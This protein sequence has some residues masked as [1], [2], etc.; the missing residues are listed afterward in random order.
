MHQN[1]HSDDQQ[2]IVRLREG[3]IKTLAELHTRY[4]KTLLFYARTLL[5][6]REDAEDV[7][8]ELFLSLLKKKEAM[9]ITKNVK[10]YLYNA[11]KYRS[12]TFNNKAKREEEVLKEYGLTITDFLPTTNRIEEAEN[13]QELMEAINTLPARL[14]TAIILCCLKEMEKKEVALKMGVSPETVTKYISKAIKRL[15]KFYSLKMF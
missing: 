14:K 15:A 6:S 12:I 5:P 7:V 2:L 8:N 4:Y 3:G 11:V 9:N 10:G 13:Q 1:L